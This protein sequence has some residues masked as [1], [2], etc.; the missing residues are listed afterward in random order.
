MKQKEEKKNS[1][2]T[3]AQEDIA[4][5]CQLAIKKD[6]LDYIALNLSADDTSQDITLSE[7]MKAEYPYVTDI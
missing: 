2:A 1:G 4:E 5:V 3:L 6:G 7:L